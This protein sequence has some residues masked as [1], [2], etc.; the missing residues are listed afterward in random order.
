[1]SEILIYIEY[2]LVF[3]LGASVASFL[4]VFLEE[5]NKS[6][7]FLGNSICKNC[8][9]KLRWY[10]LIPVFSFI[11]LK[12]KCSRCKSLIPPRLFISELLLGLFFVNLFFF[13]LYPRDNPIG[14][15]FFLFIAIY[16][17]ILS[18]EDFLYQEIASWKL[19]LFA[20]LGLLSNLSFYL[21]EGGKKGEAFFPALFSENF[22]IT[23]SSLMLYLFFILY[24]VFGKDKYMGQ[25]DF[26]VLLGILFFYGL[27][28]FVNIFIYSIWI[29]AFISI[30]FL[31]KKYKSIKNFK[32]G[33]TL[34]F[35]P[36]LFLGIFF[37]HITQY[38]I[39]V[40]KDI[41]EIIKFLWLN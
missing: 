21:I 39:L 30:L 18:Y 3:F 6:R 12:G 5:R 13:P 2:I 24:S 8:E 16:L 15:I 36:F 11:F 37:F 1:M 17:F 14:L 9:K 28:I 10:E 23:T 26:L 33:E 7:R 34:P 27:E 25:G 41:L 4:C 29:G 19:Y 38:K 32:R 20:T 40:F 22:Y 31:F 35:I